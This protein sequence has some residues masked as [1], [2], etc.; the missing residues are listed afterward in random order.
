MNRDL[1]IFLYARLLLLVLAQA[2][3]FSKLSIFGTIT[4]MIYVIFLFTYPT[5]QNRSIFLSVSFLMGLFLDLLLDSM[6]LHSICL[7]SMAYVRPKI[8]R[9]TFG[10]NFELQSFRIHKAPLQQR[11]T[12]LII[13]ILI[14]HFLYFSLEIFSLSLAGLVIKKTLLTS[15]ASFVLSLLILALFSPKKS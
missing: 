10:L 11:Y 7:L 4:P 1:P 14:H 9:F 2:M 3:V 15:L 8:M 13:S 6:A 12:F 5:H